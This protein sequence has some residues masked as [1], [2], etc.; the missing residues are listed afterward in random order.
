[1]G[2]LTYQLKLG[3]VGKKPASHELTLKAT[4]SVGCS[5]SLAARAAHVVAPAEAGKAGTI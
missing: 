4:Q 5:A 3:N 2:N 1:M